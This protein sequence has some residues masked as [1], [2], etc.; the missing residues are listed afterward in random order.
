MTATERK[1]DL[2]LTGQLRGACFEGFR[3]HSPIY[4]SA[5]LYVVSSLISM[6]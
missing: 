3:K 5:A 1:S 4:N 2:E 6:P